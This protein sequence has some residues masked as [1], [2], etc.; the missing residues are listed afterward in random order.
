MRWKS[1]ENIEVAIKPPDEDEMTDK[2]DNKSEKNLEENSHQEVAGR[3]EL[4]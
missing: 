2:E 1:L 3:L 4:I